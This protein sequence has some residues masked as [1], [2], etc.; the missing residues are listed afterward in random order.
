ML[1]N[2]RSESCWVIER[3]VIKRG[4]P[5]ARLSSECAGF[6]LFEFL[7][8][9]VALIVAIVVVVQNSREARLRQYQAGY[10]D[11][12]SSVVESGITGVIRCFPTESPRREGFDAGERCA[13]RYLSAAGCKPKYQLSPN[14]TQWT[15]DER[16][17]VILAA[18][19]SDAGRNDQLVESLQKRFPHGQRDV[20]QQ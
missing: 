18:I 19:R 6:T 15:P 2:W 12:M 9:T 1:K 16:L 11:G 10:V 5:V 20:G 3:V 4:K 8:A 13:E 7:L 17:V 14:D